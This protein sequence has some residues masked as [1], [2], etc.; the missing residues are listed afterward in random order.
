V[1]VRSVVVRGIRYR[2]G[3]SLVL[4]LLATLAVAVTVLV[5]AYARAAQQ[6]VLTERLAA[7]P[8]N[9]VALHLTADPQSGPATTAQAKARI[10]PAGLPEYAAPPIGAADVPAV[11]DDKAVARLAYR[12]GLCAHLTVSS[13]RCAGGVLVSARSAQAHGITV[14]QLL[15]V[16]SGRDERGVPLTVAGLYVPLD[17]GGAYWG[18]G[19]YFAAG[20][21]TGEDRLPRLDAVFVTD[22]ASLALPGGRPTVTLDYPMADAPVPVDRVAPLRAELARFAGAANGQQLTVDTSAG[23]V[24]DDITAEMAALSRTVPLVAV[25]LLLV[26]WFV[27]FLA[28]AGVV[29]ERAPE[30]GLAKLR[31]FSGR[32]A[33]GFGRHESTVLGL[34]AVPLG[35]AA[36]LALVGLLAALTLAPGV[37]VE[38]LRVPVGL[39]ALAALVFMLVVVGVAGG[40]PS[41]RPTLTLLR[42]V[43]IRAPRA[44]GWVELV[45]VALAAASLVA[46]FADRTGPLALLAPALLALVVG[47]GLA[48]L[49]E[50]WSRLRVGRSV[51]KGRIGRALAHAQLSRRPGGRRVMVVVTVA[52]ALVSF[53]A[54]AWDVAAQARTDAAIATVG[55]P[56]VLR[57]AAAD[58]GTLI[59]AVATA[60]GATAMPVVRATERYDA[61]PVELLAVD[62]ARFPAIAVGSTVDTAGLKG[63]GDLP[64]VVAG[65]TPADDPDA[66]TFSFPGLGEGAQRYRVAAHVA[67]LPRATGRALLMDLGTAIAAAGRASGLSDNTRL[68]YEVWAGPDAPPDLATRLAGA[69]VATIAEESIPAETARLGGGAPA[70]ALRLALVAGGVAV[71]LAVAAVLLTTYLGARTRRYELA[72]LRVA[73]VPRGL[74][75]RAVL[76]EYVQV[77][78]L[79]GL[80]GLL[81]GVGGAFLML[82]GTPLVTAGVPTVDIPVPSEVDALVGVAV[83]TVVGL[84][85]AV[86]AGLR[87]VSGATP[88]RLRDGAW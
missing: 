38:P 49:L 17:P 26:C 27:L 30:V 15:T 62:A 59:E 63:S 80:A 6:S 50:V 71:L 74:L 31:G 20:E 37:R 64:V 43:P 48:R 21:G 65:P 39:A 9:A 34:L 85:L 70:L 41:R 33:T 82:P 55:A 12:D 51:H 47:V 14:G 25:P 83:A 52:V 3:R 40:R 46:A 61:G 53:G 24:L 54:A 23:A 56:R 68:R 16:H 84:A 67:T 11:V 44:A 72:A 36:G 4:L 77:L 22:E 35:I 57:V 5:P 75:R 29:E 19:G 66:T 88:E 18:R 86:L 7:A 32:R 13:G 42:R 58:P 2:A 76:R 79:P 78:F 81:V 73:G 60:A 8:P 45:L 28:V 87:L 1:G 10:T 69:G